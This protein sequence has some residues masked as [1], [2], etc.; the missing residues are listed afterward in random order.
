MSN[1][2][3]SSGNRRTNGK[4]KKQRIMR[5]LL[6]LVSIFIVLAVAT[7]FTTYSIVS[8]YMADVPEFDPAKILPEHTSF[9]YD[10]D[11]NEVTPLLGAENRIII[12]FDEISEDLINAFIAIEDDRFYEHPGF[13]VRGI[14]RA[15]YHNIF[16]RSG[17]IQGG[18]TITQ[19]LVK[20][21]F[22][23]S[24]RTMKRK[25]QEL[26]VSYQLERSYTKKEILELYLNRIFFDFNAYGVEAAAQTYFAKSATDVTLAEAAILA[27]IPNLPGK[28][29]PYRNLEE[30]KKRQTLVLNR[31]EELG[32]ITSAEKQEA[33]N[34]ELVLAG[35]P[36]RTY[37]FPYFIDHVVLDDTYGVSGILASLPQF[38]DLSNAEIY[39]IIYKGGLKI[40]TTLDQEKQKFVEDTLNNESLYR[41]ADV[42][43]EGKP[44]QN[45]S[46]AV[47]ADP[48]TGHVAAIVG[49]REYDTGTNRFNRATD[50]RMQAGS[51][52][53]PILAFAPAFNEGAA[54]PGTVLDDAPKVWQLSSGTYAPNNFGQGFQGL[55]T[56]RRA[57]AL[58]RNIPAITLLDEI[59]IDTAKE[60]AKNMGI[61]TMEND[62]GLSMVVG[63]LD[64][65]VSVYEVAQAFS[66][67]ANEGVRTDLT[68]I[69]KIVDGKGNVIYE[70]EPNHE[71]VLTPQAAWMTT[72][73]LQDA[74]RYGTAAG[75]QIGRPAA[76]KTGTS[77]NNQDVW[78]AT[79]TPDYVTVFWQGR[80]SWSSSSVDGKLISGRDTNPFVTPIMK[81]IHEGM[82][83]RDFSR[84]DGL[85]NVSIC[86][87]SGLLPGEECPSDHIVSDWFLPNNAPGQVCDLHVQVEVCSESGLL[88]SEFCPED[89]RE[90]RT[91]FD[92]PDYLVTDSRW[93]GRSGRGPA[94][95]GDGNEPPTEVCDVHT[96]K[97]GGVSNLRGRVNDDGS[98][99]LSWNQATDASGYLIY[100]DNGSNGEAKLINS[101]PVSG[102]SYTDK[103]LSPGTYTYQVV[104]I[105]SEGVT[106]SPAS[107]SVQVKELPPPDEDPPPKD[108]DDDNDNGGNDDNDDDDNND[109]NNNGNGQG[110]RNN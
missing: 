79:Y 21:A 105:T 93:N 52:L 28:F 95:A 30:S 10:K 38:S 1:D 9:I 65:G 44:V 12:S 57:L 91:F 82:P 20:N 76:A 60:Y 70:H 94:D 26:Y 27:G 71:D 16:G 58:S 15:A 108:D 41:L 13:D 80:D 84:P 98:V 3:Q 7:G 106:S 32:M 87:K 46:A 54:S 6:I 73:V 69:T 102:T 61:T 39:D 85:R 55:M 8:A 78:L 29:S 50:G 68:T 81:F 45:Q 100:R 48:K 34:E 56:A 42:R 11:G 4:I 74:V 103:G 86:N 14:T 96:Y 88:F 104:A 40:Y 75:M 18:S 22:F 110:N 83:S 35:T 47:V 24:D 17:S 51:T 59:G 67:L 66:V 107:V 49:G 97:P 77:Q 109:N 101:N 36:K 2:N 53:K 63:G 89:H 5:L 43:E 37:P 19:Q 92:R 62:H 25:I 23:S 90:I 72:S 64:K 99:S 33:L 31:M